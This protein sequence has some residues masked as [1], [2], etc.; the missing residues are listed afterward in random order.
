VSKKTLA[1]GT[2]LPFK[3]QTAATVQYNILNDVC[4]IVMLLYM[5]YF[6]F[7]PIDEPIRN[8]NDP[9]PVEKEGCFGVVKNLGNNNDEST[10]DDN[11][12]NE[13]E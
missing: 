6:V 7:I 8:V 13:K 12:D 5:L 2:I 9:R 10:V 1:D 4:Q 3:V 11:E